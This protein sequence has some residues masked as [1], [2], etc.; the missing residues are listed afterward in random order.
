MKNPAGTQEDRVLKVL[1][2]AQNGLIEGQWVEK[3]GWVNKQFF[4]RTMGLT[5]AGR[6]IHNL[7]HERGIRIEHSDF[8]DEHGFK[9]YRL[10]REIRGIDICMT[11]IDEV[12]ENP[13]SMTKLL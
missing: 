11:F 4:I 3:D 7:E 5:Q 10:V 8:K 2:K 6:A 1:R 13:P 9:S 12:V